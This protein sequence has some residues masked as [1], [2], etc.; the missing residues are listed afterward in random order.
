M[1]AK[2]IRVTITYTH[3]G[4]QPPVYLA[5]SFSMP[6]WYPQEMDFIAEDHNEHRFHKEVLADEGGQFQYKFRIGSGDWWVLDENAPTGTFVS[7][8][9]Y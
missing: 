5:G 1:A 3:P 9:I 4:T 7:V 6:A 8:R 2:K